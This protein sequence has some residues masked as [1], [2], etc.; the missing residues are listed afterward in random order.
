M[1]GIVALVHDVIVLLGLFALLG[2]IDPRIE[3]D[4]GFIAALLTVVGYSINDSVVIFDRLRENLRI[5]RKEP[6]EKIVNDS[7]LETMSRSINTV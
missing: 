4:S 6:F 5:R 2:K 7:L 1:A 3:V